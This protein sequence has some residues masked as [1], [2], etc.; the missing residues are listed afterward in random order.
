MNDITLIHRIVLAIL[1]MLFTFIASQVWYFLW[2]ET[3]YFNI[4]QANSLNFI[5][6]DGSYACSDGKNIIEFKLITP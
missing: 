3:T 5:T 1:V 6:I 2:K 4:C